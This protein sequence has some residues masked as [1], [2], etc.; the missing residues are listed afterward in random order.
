MLGC[1]AGQD[2][3]DGLPLAL[4]AGIR[5]ESEDVGLR[6]GE[7][8]KFF[9]AEMR[10]AGIA[11]DRFLS[12]LL[13]SEAAR[14]VYAGTASP[15]M[16][17]L[18]EF[19]TRPGKRVRPVLYLASARVFAPGESWLSRPRL[20]VAA[21]L[22]MLH[23]FILIHDD[24]ID[25]SE[26]RRGLPTLHRGLEKRVSTF[27]DRQRIG[28]SL[29]LVMGDILFALGQR[30]ILESGEP[31][32]AQLLRKWM[33]YLLETGVG[34][35]A[36]IVFGSRDIGKIS[37]ADIEQM[38]LQ[39]TTRYTIEAPLVMGAL[40]GG[41]SDEE[42]AE[43][44]GIAAPAGLAFQIQNDLQEFGRFEVSDDIPSDLLEGK[45]TYLMRTAFEML[46]EN[47]QCILQL[48]ING[49]RP[50]EA[51]VTKVRELVVGSGAVGVLQRKVVELCEE[52][53]ARAEGS[54]F[55]GEIR[56]ALLSLLDMLCGITK[57]TRP[58]VA[59]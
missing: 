25:R 42:I 32:A 27:A 5:V 18:C 36:D 59:A 53:R 37:L 43:I 40:L 54:S 7:N 10:E 28:A 34:E 41:A 13:R 21:A 44:S 19:V 24:L 12:D 1:G 11:V 22:E 47:D 8:L 3:P 6:M 51:T 48:C 29:A 17:E 56:A 15:L 58:L 14:P 49:I 20:A 50:S 39:K 2:M 26:L 45:K 30:T 38:Y 46:G 4:K 55:D 31:R 16:E 23:A 52:A 33:D 57:V 9:A 35:A